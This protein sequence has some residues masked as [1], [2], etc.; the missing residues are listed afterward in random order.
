MKLELKKYTST[1][2]I[3]CVGHNYVE[4][5]K[6]LNS[7]MPKEPTIFMKPYAALNLNSEIHIPK[8]GKEFHYEAELVVRIGKNGVVETEEQA[9]EFISGLA[10]GLD[11]TLRDIQRQLKI[12]ALPWE[13]AKA[14]ESSA[15]ITD[16]VAYDKNIDLQALE[17]ECYVNNVL[18]QK[19]MTSDMLFTIKYLLK[20]I[21]S[22]WN[23]KV[24]DLIFTGTPVG[25]GELFLGD[26][27]TLKSTL[28]HNETWTII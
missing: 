21:S 23:F 9:D 1:P 18:R 14:F 16:F 28:K 8:Y 6:E 25:V 17:F 20:H 11:L 24:D 3:F 10:I 2:R 4:H 13:K 12:T 22:I 26:K 15:V 5:I 7:E 19:A 27:I